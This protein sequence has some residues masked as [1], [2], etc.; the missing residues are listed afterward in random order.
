[1]KTGLMWDYRGSYKSMS[2][3]SARDWLKALNRKKF[4]G[5]SDWRL[6]TLE[7]GASLIEKRKWYGDLHIFS[8]F[9]IIQKEIWTADVNDNNSNWIISFKKGRVRTPSLFRKKSFVRPVRRIK[10]RN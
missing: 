6:P 1:M 2:I 3:S 8:V 9:S 7:E 10:Y 5:F 4:A